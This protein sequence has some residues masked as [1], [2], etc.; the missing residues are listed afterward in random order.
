[1]TNDLTTLSGALLEMKDEL[2]YQ[3]GQK[4]VTASYDSSTGLLGL[5]GKISEIQSGGSTVLFG[6]ACDSARGLI[7][8]GSS[9]AV[10]GSGASMTMTYDSTENAYKVS[11]DGNYYSMIPISDLNDVDNYK[12]SA[13]FKGL[14]KSI[15]GVGFCLDNRNDSTSYSYAIW[16]ESVTKF[17]GKQFNLNSDG[18]VNQHTGLSMDANTW[19]HME[20][21]VDGDELTGNLYN[22]DTLLAT[23]TT[24]LTVNNKQV[25]IFLLTQNGTT[26]SACYV[27][28][29]KAE[30]IY[31]HIDKCQA[32]NTSKYGSYIRL[33]GNASQCTLTYD[34]TNN[35]YVV[36]GTGNY[37]SGF[38]IPNTFNVS[39]IKIRLKVKLYNT[40]AFNQCYIGVHDSSDITT[41]IANRV[42]GDNK[43]QYFY[44]HC[45]SE[46]TV[47]SSYSYNTDWYYLELVKNGSNITGTVYDSSMNQLATDTRTG[48]ANFNNPVY[49][50]AMQTELGYEYYIQEI[51]AEPI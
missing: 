32:D 41:T 19:Y 4:G 43:F 25:G 10:R 16:E 38:E 44:N 26:N 22:G 49:T 28:N 33:Q 7:N 36:D 6:D 39:N 30:N 8:Y 34:S 15:N 27:K 24:T 42:R 17:V 21:I 47:N 23:D 50:F 5:I 3:L 48:V 31:A 2:I 20:L 45:D 37:F 35:Y 40:S 29:I 12:I 14:S 46:A 9:V 18:T 11:G 13:D 51:K 1:M